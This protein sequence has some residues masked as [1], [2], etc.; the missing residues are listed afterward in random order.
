MYKKCI[1]SDRAALQPVDEDTFSVIIIIQMAAFLI[2]GFK[3]QG[4]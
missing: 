1:R 3:K 4:L 2:Y